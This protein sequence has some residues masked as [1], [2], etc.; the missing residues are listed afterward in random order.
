M[1]IAIIIHIFL[2]LVNGAAAAGTTIERDILPPEKRMI[3]TAEM[4]MR[5]LNFVAYEILQRAETPE[6]FEAGHDTIERAHALEAAINKLRDAKPGDARR[7]ARAYL[8]VIMQRVEEDE[9]S[10]VAKTGAG[11]G[12]FGWSGKA[13]AHSRRHGRDCNEQLA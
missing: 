9:R 10:E 12:G 8:S 1:R 13:S 4:W 6:E 11:F 5:E 3:L 2:V 7:K